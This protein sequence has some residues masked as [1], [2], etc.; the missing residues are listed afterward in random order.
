[1][2]GDINIPKTKAVNIF[3]QF[4]RVLF[5]LYVIGHV[6]QNITNN[7]VCSIDGQKLINLNQKG[8]FVLILLNLISMFFVWLKE[9]FARL[10]F[11]VMYAVNICWSLILVSQA[12]L[13]IVT[14]E[15]ECPGVI[16]SQ[17]LII[18]FHLKVHAEVLFTFL[19]P[20]LFAFRQIYLPTTLYPV[21][22]FFTALNSQIDCS[23][24]VEDILFGVIFL[25]IILFGIGLPLNFALLCSK[26]PTAPN[27]FRF[28][29]MI[30]IIGQG[31]IMGIKQN[32][33]KALT[34]QSESNTNKECSETALFIQSYPFIIPISILFSLSLMFSLPAFDHEDIKQKLM[35]QRLKPQINQ[36]QILPQQDSPQKDDNLNQK[37]VINDGKSM[38]GT[39]LR[40]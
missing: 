13:D 21:Y 18:V 1:M 3:I 2:Q 27:L 29:L 26:K 14:N 37:S 8:S 34:Y 31:G 33:Q 30:G 16:L 22:L 6:L 40:R 23:K 9:P 36:N 17:K 32:Q 38:Y 19:S 4:A 24:D 39:V 15:N 28:L 10:E 7:Q 12:Y 20:V 11:F 25:N 35:E 5:Y